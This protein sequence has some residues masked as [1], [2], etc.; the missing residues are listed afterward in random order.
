MENKIFNVA[1]Y[2]RKET[3]LKTIESVYNYADEINISLNLY[4]EIPHQLIDNKIK[5]FITDN[6][7][8]DAFKFINLENSNGYFFTIDDDLIYS[9]EYVDLMIDGVEK[10]NRKKIV[11]L[12]GRYYEKFPI[13]S[14]YK[15]YSKFYHCLHNLNNDE[16]VHIGGTGVMCFHTDTIK[17]PINYFKLPNMADIWV[18]KY[19]YE[20]NIDIICLKHNKVIEYQ[21]VKTTIYD[22]SVKN[23][24]NQTKLINLTFYE[25]ILSIIIPTYKNPNYLNEALESILKNNNF[26]EILVGIDGC[27]ETLNYIKDKEFDSRIRFFYFNKNFGPYIVRN[28]L[29]TLATTENILFFDSDDIMIDGMIDDISNILNDTQFVKPMYIEFTDNLPKL[30]KTNLFGE[31]VFAIKKDLFLSMNG[32]EPWKVSADSEFMSRLYKNNI[33]FKYTNTPS[34]YRRIHNNSLTQNPETNLS[35][36]LRHNYSRIINSKSNFG[37][38]SKLHIEDYIEITPSFIPSFTPSISEKRKETAL[39]TL[40]KVLS[41]GK[42][43]IPPP[44]TNSTSDDV[45]ITTNENIENNNKPKKQR[46]FK[47]PIQY[48]ENSLVKLNMIKKR[49]KNQ[50]IPNIFSNKGTKR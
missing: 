30:K 27:E 1:S 7:L 5:I 23:D 20:N 18:G 33:Q 46:E 25:K 24:Y 11:T 2:K 34:F 41:L 38:L 15:S 37:P 8:G 16:K 6:S 13:K 47:K 48:A 3:L 9:K 28:T 40:S 35:S 22:E 12:H 32:F 43:Y 45:I 14:Y 36:K 44:G 31:G 17:I 29:A 26:F 39:N 42:K 4:D 19:S 49:K 50:D 21:K 10:Y